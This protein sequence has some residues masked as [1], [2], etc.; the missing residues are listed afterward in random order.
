MSGTATPAADLDVNGIA[1]ESE[2]GD[3]AIGDEAESISV[4]SLHSLPPP[5]LL[6]LLLEYFLNHVGK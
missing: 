5:P 2:G 3:L 1:E 4:V 6:P